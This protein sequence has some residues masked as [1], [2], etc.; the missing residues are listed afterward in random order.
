[1]MSDDE[2]KRAFRKSIDKHLEESLYNVDRQ[3]IQ[4]NHP[5]KR[6]VH[7][8]KTVF[9]E[10][11]HQLHTSNEEDPVFWIDEKEYMEDACL[12]FL[13]TRYERAFHYDANFPLWGSR[14]WKHILASMKR[15]GEATKVFYTSIPLLN[16]DEVMAK[17]VYVAEK[18]RYGSHPDLYPDV[19][20]F[21]QLVFESNTT[22]DRTVV[23][24]GDIHRYIELSI[25]QL[26]T[27]KRLKQVA[28]SGISS[29]STVS[30]E[31][32]VW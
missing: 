18:E 13:D 32:K 7:I 8:G 3:M 2:L 31:L 1:M 11:Q 24:S 19:D 15:C 29:H 21:L 28:S 27:N 17:I 14:Q 25:K 16:M 23:V 12:F 9:H 30:N 4:E 20:R 26:H 5:K 22:L 10:Y 6:F